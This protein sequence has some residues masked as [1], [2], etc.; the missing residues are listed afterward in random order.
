MSS[1]EAAF[2][3]NDEDRS[4]ELSVGQGQ[5]ENRQKKG[6][7]RRREELGDRR[8]RTGRKTRAN[9]HLE[10]KRKSV[11]NQKT[12]QKGIPP[13]GQESALLEKKMGF[14]AQ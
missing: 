4:G 9:R 5:L 6:E 11:G 7:K 3:V 13:L 1:K 14:I 12:D 2:L 8:R 10:K